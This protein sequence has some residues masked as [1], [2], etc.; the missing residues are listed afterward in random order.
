VTNSPPTVSC[1]T[2]ATVECGTA[3]HV[4]VV[5]ADPDGDALTVVWSL[6][7]SAVQTNKVGASV[8]NTM[9]SVSFVA[10]LP[11]GSNHVAVTATDTSTNSASCSTT[12]TVVDTTPPVIHSVKATPNV[13]WP[14]NHKMVEVSVL[15]D[16]TDTCSHTT[17]KI[18]KVTSNE[19]AS[20]LG[21]GDIASDWQITGDH[22]VNLRAERSGKGKGR[23]YTITIQAKDASGNLSLPQTV[24][25][26]VP[27]DQG[28]GK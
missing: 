10:T 24:T 11:L 20:G 8:S 4:T 6:N 28:K 12:I 15:A 13:L 22:K 26:T 3:T 21:D 23:I 2:D 9:A 5:V 25:V 27:H 19:P 16:V 17:W 14:P 18:T 7:G 1:P